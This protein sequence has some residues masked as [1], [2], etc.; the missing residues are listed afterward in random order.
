MKSGLED[1]SQT[2]LFCDSQVIGESMLEDINSALNYGDAPNIYK[3]EDMEE[4][5]KVC[6]WVLSVALVFMVICDW[7]T[8]LARLPATVVAALRAHCKQLGVA[9]TKSNIFNA[10]IKKV[11]A[12]LHFILAM[13][14]LGLSFRTWLRM[15]PSLTNCCTVNWFSEVRS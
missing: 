8:P 15:F 4:I 13:S 11:K 10:Y 3:K 6:K 14:P 1:K 2:F 7:R 5:M 12:H 9:P